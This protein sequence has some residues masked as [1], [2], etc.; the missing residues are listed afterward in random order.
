MVCDFTESSHFIGSGYYALKGHSVCEWVGC[1]ADNCFLFF[2][3]FLVIFCQPLSPFSL[4][5]FSSHAFAL[6]FLTTGILRPRTA[7]QYSTPAILIR[8]DMWMQYRQ[9]LLQQMICDNTVL[10]ESHWH[11]DKINPPV[12]SR[13]RWWWCW[14]D[15][16]AE[17]ETG[18]W[19]DGSW[20]SCHSSWY[21]RVE[22]SCETAARV[23]YLKRQ[24]LGWANDKMVW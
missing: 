23:D 18:W 7:H 3:L 14:A 8:R 11:S 5:V 6:L 13:H 2:N 22:G 24:C 15:G 16:S 4:L 20:C 9:C 19:N 12:E 1:D 17:T 10:T 21:S